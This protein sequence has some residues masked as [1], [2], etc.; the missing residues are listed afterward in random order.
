[1]MKLSPSNRFITS[2]SGGRPSEWVSSP[3]Q[4]HHGSP[5]R[6]I[7]NV[8]LGDMFPDKHHGRISRHHTHCP[9]GGCSPEGLEAASVGRMSLAST[10]VRR[11]V[12][13]NRP[14]S[15]FGDL[16]GIGGRDIALTLL[17]VTLVTV[18]TEFLA[19]RCTHHIP[20]FLF[21]PEGMV[22]CCFL[23]PLVARTQ[24]SFTPLSRRVD[25]QI[26]R[27]HV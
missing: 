3:H 26:G 18:F 15:V 27:A 23:C 8:C 22:W 17:V 5:F 9:P 4:R 1:M 2:R 11:T 7:G 6:S 16:A 24:A 19:T 21:A 12:D 14:Q 25:L 20:H 10:R 13:Q